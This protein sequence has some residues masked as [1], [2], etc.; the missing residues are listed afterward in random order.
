[1]KASTISGYNGA[2]GYFKISVSRDRADW[3]AGRIENLG[4]NRGGGAINDPYR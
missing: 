2:T 4:L 3:N 1:M